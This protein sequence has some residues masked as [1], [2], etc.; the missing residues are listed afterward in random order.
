M[1]CL[2]DALRGVTVLGDAGCLRISDGG[3][4]WSAADG[5]VIDHHR[6]DEKQSP[7]ELIGML[8]ISAA[9]AANP[10]GL[11]I[12]PS[13]TDPG[14]M[15]LYIADRAVDNNSDPNENDGKVYEFMIEDFPMV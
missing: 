8:D 5:R 13:S 11:A 14:R 4:E 10:A 2:L 7:G 15:S 9:G 6:E 1:A 12:A 3:F